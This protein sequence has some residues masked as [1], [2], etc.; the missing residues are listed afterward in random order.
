M[1]CETW[2]REQFG[3]PLHPYGYPISEVRPMPRGTERTL[4][5]VR[6]KDAQGRLVIRAV[7]REG[8]S[9]EAPK[10]SSETRAKELRHPSR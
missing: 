10:D 4:T 5:Y 2:R 8:P 9:P 7:A 1:P 3:G 6:E